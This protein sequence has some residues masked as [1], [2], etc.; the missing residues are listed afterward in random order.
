MFTNEPLITVYITN[1]NYGKYIE[2]AIKSVLSQTLQDYE[3]IIIDDGSVDNSREIIEKYSQLENVTSIYQKNKGLNVSNNIAL[4]YARG[5][6]IIRLDADDYFDEHALQVLSGILEKNDDVGLV[7][8]DYS[9]INEFDEVADIVR[10]HDFDEVKMLDQ[11]A[12]G[13]CTMIRTHCLRELGGYDEEYRCQD[14]YELWIRFIQHY[15]VQNVNLPLFYYRQHSSNLTRN[16]K[17]ILETRSRILEKQSV[18]SEKR[19]SALIIV[20]VRGKITDPHSIALEDL[21]DKKVIDWTLQSCLQ[22]KQ[23]QDTVLTSPDNDVL[24]YVKETY[25]NDIIT[26]K[27][28]PDMAKL[29]T[30]LNETINHAINHY[31]SLNKTDPD[32]IVQLSVESPFR[33][34]RHVDSALDVINLFDADSVVAVRPETD[35]FYQHD[36][37][38]LKSLQY[39]KRLKLE[40]DALYRRVGNM[41]VVKA[42]YFNATGELSGGKTGHI[43]MEECYSMSID[44]DWQW[45]V[46]SMIARDMQ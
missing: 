30:Y 29:N 28:D 5:K 4:R 37:E 25:G 18:L 22:V 23:A 35:L 42:D 39:K 13:A 10:R 16:E 20:P 41:H 21:G 34:A 26:I 40:A 9:M 33:L 3:I 15:K 38:H 45:E 31:V 6:Y 11:P 7:F 2:K 14:G 12:H 43:V 24:E 19:R 44:S 32:T 1:H 17:V 46:A 36:G 27:R 8:P